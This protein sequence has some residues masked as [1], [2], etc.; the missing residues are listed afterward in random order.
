M[1]KNLER[2]ATRQPKVPETNAMELLGS[3]LRLLRRQL[4]VVIST[5]FLLSSLGVVYVLITPP[6]YTA[7]GLLVTDSK[8]LQLTQ[9]FGEA[10][11]DP[12]ELETEVEVLKSDNVLLPVVKELR[13]TE[14]PGFEETIGLRAKLFGSR[15]PIPKSAREEHA[16]QVLLDLLTATRLP[17]T[18]IIEISYKSREP[19]FAAQVVNAVANSFIREQFESRAQ[20]AGQASAWLETRVKELGEEASR[21]EQAVVKFKRDNNIVD[22]GGKLTAEQQLGEI[23]TKLVNARAETADA[24]A[25]L[26]RIDATLARNRSDSTLNATVADALKNEVV[27]NLRSQ[28]F[29]LANRE[30]DYSA[31][32]GK[33]HLAVIKLRVLRCGEFGTRFSMSSSDSLRFTRAILRSPS[34]RRIN[35]RKNIQPPC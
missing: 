6:T 4:W 12:L 32:Y 5:T 9:S 16:V 15:G 24:R 23:N 1:L 10:T 35:S 27:N 18:R 3:A 20:G 30:A 21:A 28:Y 19:A 26:S 11:I 34:T 8:R 22:T 17:R 33:D 31:R 14:H 7:K 2:A 29:V 25:K 13:L